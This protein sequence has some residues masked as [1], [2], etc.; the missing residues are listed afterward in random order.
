[1]GIEFPNKILNR[2]DKLQRAQRHAFRVIYSE[3]LLCSP[4]R[5]NTFEMSELLG[6]V[7]YRPE[8]MQGYVARKAKLLPEGFRY[9]SEE[10]EHFNHY[11]LHGEVYKNRFP[12][13]LR[14]QENPGFAIEN[15]SNIWMV[16]CTVATVMSPE[17][18]QMCKIKFDGYPH[19]EHSYAR[20]LGTHAQIPLY[21][22][23]GARCPIPIKRFPT[24]NVNGWLEQYE[25]DLYSTHDL[26]LIAVGTLRL[27]T[28]L[29]AGDYLVNTCH[30]E[31]RMRVL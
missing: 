20:K 28:L 16:S 22:T 2:R 30:L 24:R 9:D 7:I 21:V 4:Q 26:V 25:G 23:K 5:N 13:Q 31:Q 15:N 12:M 17:C 10:N 18:S 27:A 14:W 19:Y 6:V 1:M 29:E 8:A 11:W 3:H